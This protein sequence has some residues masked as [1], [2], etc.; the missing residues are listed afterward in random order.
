MFTPNDDSLTE[1]YFEKSRY[2]KIPIFSF[3]YA[4]FSHIFKQDRLKIETT[5]VRLDIN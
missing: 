5:R 2:K 1:Q 4:T 3:S